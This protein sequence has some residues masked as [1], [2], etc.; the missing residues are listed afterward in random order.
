MN[1]SI[2]KAKQKQY[3]D[4]VKQITPTHSL[5][6]N[7]AKAFLTGGV[8]CV[9][10]QIITNFAKSRGLDQDMA[11][12]WC[13]VTLVFISVILTGFNIYPKIGKF[14]GAGSLVPITGFANSVDRPCPL[15][16]KRRSGLWNRLQDFHHCRSCDS[17][18]NHEFLDC[19]SDLLSSE[20]NGGDFMNPQTPARLTGSAS[21]SFQNPVYVV[22]CASVVGKKEGE[23]PLGSKFDLVCEELCLE[24]LP[25]KLRK[26]P[27]KK[28]QP[29]WPLEK[30][31]LLQGIS[32]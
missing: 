31:D 6:M 11:G 16:I 12:T 27:C 9:V 10:G 3:A 1:S 13:S 28:K 22:S 4:Y 29:H 14:G 7:M 30:P 2:P 26:A 5:P 15:N 21:M 18:R 25:G 17:L 23:G 32:A 8:I 24:R 19:R 20:N